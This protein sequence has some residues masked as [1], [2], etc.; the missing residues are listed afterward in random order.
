MLSKSALVNYLGYNQPGRPHG[1]VG[2][3]DAPSDLDFDLP[4]NATPVL[5]GP[6]ASELG[7]PDIGPAILAVNCQ[8]LLQRKLL[9]M[10]TGTT[11]NVMF[12]SSCVSEILFKKYEVLALMAS[13]F[14]IR[15]QFRNN[16]TNGSKGSR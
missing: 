16:S 12:T 8:H 14:R 9:L 3:A 5:P 1:C 2:I 7:L 13:S 4:A 11:S 15:N 10:C 6:A